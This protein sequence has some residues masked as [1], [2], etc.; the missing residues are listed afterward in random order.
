[1]PLDDP[2]DF[3]DATLDDLRALL[4]RD[5]TRLWGAEQDRDAARATYAREVDEHPHSDI[6]ELRDRLDAEHR[7]VLREAEAGAAKTARQVEARSRKIAEVCKGSRPKLTRT[8]MAAAGAQS[9]LV[10]AFVRD[11]RLPN[12]VDRIQASVLADDRAAMHAFAT[13]SGTR[14]EVRP[15]ERHPTLREDRYQTERFELRKLLVTIEGKLADPHFELLRKEALE[16]A[17]QAAS[18]ARKAEKPAV[19]DYIDSKPFVFQGPN[20]VPWGDR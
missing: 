11:A 9:P 16:Q 7:P 17:E 13:H 6:P 10:E 18:A 14:L 4:G 12:L 8:E 20:D 15:E 19:E 3:A 1:M 5:D 2:F